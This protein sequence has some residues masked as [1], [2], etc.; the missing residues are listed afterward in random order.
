MWSDLVGAGQDERHVCGRFASQ[1]A[2]IVQ[3]VLPPIIEVGP[4]DMTRDFIDVRDVASALQLL[5]VHGT[6]GE[7]YNVASGIEF[8]IRCVLSTMLRYA[9]L[10]DTVRIQ[11]LSG[12][13]ADIPRHFAD[14]QRLVALGFQPQYDLKQSLQH[15]LRYYIDTVS[16]AAG[17]V[18]C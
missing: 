4:L 16:K 3:E 9:G 18:L 14:I 1:I 15:L 8:P 11:Q 5:A 12:R 6:P 7:V 2:A 10:E 13:S 17:A